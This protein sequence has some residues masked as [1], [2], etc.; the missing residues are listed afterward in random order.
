MI[1]AARIGGLVEQI[2]GC[3]E[4]LGS[5]PDRFAGCRCGDR[6]LPAAGYGSSLRAVVLGIVG[7]DPT[8][9]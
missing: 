6:G 1:Y 3:R 9:P 4:P 7:R 8:L 2:R 5:D